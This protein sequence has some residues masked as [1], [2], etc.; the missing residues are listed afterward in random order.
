MIG[1]DVTVDVCGGDVS[2]GLQLDTFLSKF[3]HTFTAEVIDLEGI[4]EW[5]IEADARRTI[6]NHISFLSDHSAICDT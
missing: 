4:E 3:K 6:N 2:K 1:D 5:V